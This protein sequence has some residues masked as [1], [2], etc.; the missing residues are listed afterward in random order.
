[1][2]AVVCVNGK[3]EQVSAVTVAELLATRGI[4]KPKGV[5]VALNGAVVPAS[6]W[7]AAR[8]A[9]GDR[10]EIVKPFGGG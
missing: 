10:I 6:A 7:A 9:A 3:D 2:S 5:A 8:L 4:T 1:M